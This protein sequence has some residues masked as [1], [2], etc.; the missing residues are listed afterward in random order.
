MES[1]SAAS[2]TAVLLFLTLNL[3]LEKTSANVLLYH[4]VLPSD[5]SS[6][7][8]GVQP[9]V[10]SE[11]TVAKTDSF[12]TN[13]VLIDTCPLEEGRYTLRIV[14]QDL[15]AVTLNVINFTAMTIF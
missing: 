11:N 15:T 8:N 14:N 1:E 5:G 12:V 9:W 7:T 13:S 3:K 2:L 4:D 6:V 10:L